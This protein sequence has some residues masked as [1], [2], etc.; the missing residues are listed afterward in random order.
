MSDV[1]G[2]G[3]AVPEEYGQ[4][5]YTLFRARNVI[6]RAGKYAVVFMFVFIAVGASV[7]YNRGS[8]GGFGLE[9][10]Y[11]KST[12]GAGDVLGAI[13]IC[14]AVGTGPTEWRTVQ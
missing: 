14:C 6:V 7:K 8:C 12:V 5:K 3:G 1:I 13:G 9:H 11:S 2:L 4:E 10:R